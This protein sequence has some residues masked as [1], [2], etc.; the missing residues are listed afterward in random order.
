MTPVPASATRS[1]AP[2]IGPR[3]RFRDL[4]AAEWI[5]LWSLRSTYGSLALIAVSAVLF[6]AR[7]ALADQYNWP[8]Y[9]PERRA[10]FDPIHDAFPEE[11][12]LFII[13]AAGA[14]GALMIAGEYASGQIRTTFAAVPARR[15]VVAA[16]VV[17]LGAVMLVVGVLA[18]AAS[19]W[20]SQAILAD[21][22]AGA[23][24]GEP[25]ALRAVVASAL[26][27]PVCALIGFGVGALVRHTAPAIVI[28]AT[29]L[30]LA[31]MAFDISNRWTAVAHNA[32]PVPAWERLVGNP[33]VLPNL[34][35]AT[36]AGSWTVFA[37]WPLVAA[38]LATVVVHRREP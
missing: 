17:V 19:F 37:V 22:Q 35:V 1:A 8:D 11:G 33:Y 18:A 23:S 12:W 20:L 25:Q 3:A 29:L 38:L 34:H 7:A 36:V 30:L 6:S 13:L 27:L 9:S 21:R 4:V 15:A 2:L 14:V 28:T 26:L 5:K 31:P 10:A 24:I 16:K 32:L